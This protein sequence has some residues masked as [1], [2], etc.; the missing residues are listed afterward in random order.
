MIDRLLRRL[1]AGAL[2]SCRSFCAG[3]DSPLC[4]GTAPAWGNGM[5]RRIGLIALFG[6][7]L[8]CAHARS[9]LTANE[10]RNEAS[11]AEARANRELEQYE[12]ISRRASRGPSTSEVSSDLLVHD[13][14]EQHLAAVDRQLRVAHDH[15]AAAQ[16][17]EQFEDKACEGLSAAQRAACPLMTPFLEAVRELPKGVQLQFKPTAPVGVVILQMRCHLAFAKAKGFTS[18][19]C[20]LYL[21]GVRFATNGTVVE[22]VSD[23]P[24]Q[25]IE[26]QNECRR[27]FGGPP[28]EPTS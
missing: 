15:R 26:I 11:I 16:A 17:L 28:T 5:H 22:I 1:T 18:P 14:P 12:P 2:G 7:A 23:D 8:S 19:S 6:S 9:D 25:A 24:R 27:M 21:K 10:H 20:P 13:A 4:I 3:A